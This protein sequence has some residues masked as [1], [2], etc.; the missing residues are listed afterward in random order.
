MGAARAGI[1]PP[2][3]GHASGRALRRSDVARGGRSRV[4]LA[5]L[6]R[7]GSPPVPARHAGAVMTART[8]IASVMVALGCG[9]SGPALSKTTLYV[10]NYV[11]SN[12]V[13]SVASWH[14]L[15]ALGTLGGVVTIDPSTGAIEKILRSP[16]GLP[17]NHVLSVAVSPSGLLWAGTAESGIARLRPDGTFRRTL[18]SFDGLP[19]DRVQ[20]LYVHGD[21]LWVATTSG[22]STFA[23]GVWT[24]RASSLIPVATSLTLFADTLWAA[25]SAGPYRYASGLFQPSNAGHLFASQTLGVSGSSLYSG[26]AALGVF[27]YAPPSGWVAAPPGLPNPR[28]SSLTVGP[29]G[30][31]W[32]GTLGGA[33]R[34]GPGANA[35]EAFLSDGPLVNGTQHAVVSAR[36]VWLTTGNAFPAGGSRGVVLHFDGASW[37]ALTNASTGGAFQEADA[38]GIVAAADSRLWIGH[39]CLEAPDRP[40]VDR[41]DPATGTWDTPPAYNVWAMAQSPA[42]PVVAA[43]VEH[44]NGA[45][46]FDA[47]SG[48]LVDSLTPGNSGISSNNLRAAAFDAAGKGWFGSGF[49]GL[50]VWDGKGTLAHGDDAWV[51]YVVQPSDQVTSIAVM[52]PQAAWIG[53]SLGAGRIE[54]GLFTR[55]LVG[56]TLPSGQVA[57]LALDGSGNVWIATAAGLVRADASGAGS[58]EIFTTADGLVDNEIH[59]LAWDPDRGVLWV[60]TANGISR[61]A[62]GVPGDPAITSGTYVYPNPTRT[63]GGTLNLGG[64]QNALDGEI[65]VLAGSGLHR[66]HCDPASNEIWDLTNA[67]GEPAPSGVYLVVLRDRSGGTKILRAAVVR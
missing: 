43:S 54:N 46:L 58:V 66:F 47:A 18:S 50:D 17:S 2:R 37:N 29:D 52:S 31:L 41:Y 48:T 55:V 65:R 24:S 38:F 7:R 40:R 36:G 27:R 5:L 60:G 45:Y 20:S 1:H 35:W 56:P 15:L 25:T 4:P 9:A 28:V 63:A 14:G 64:I 57:D 23:S 33:A 42:G 3:R 32:A 12:E 34:L 30:A 26:S 61:V 22:L 21:T 51:H 19:S 10:K 53:T 49:S 16:S 11:N 13:Q 44:E 6:P 59:A 39:C 8:M 67:K 62:A